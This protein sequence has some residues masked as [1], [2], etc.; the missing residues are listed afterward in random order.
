MS[1]HKCCECPECPQGPQGIQGVEGL[2]GVSGQNGSTGAQGPAGSQGVQGAIGPQGPAGDSGKAEY[3]EVYSNNA[4]SLS[5][6]PGA[7]QAG[8]VTLFENTIVA[9]SG[10]DVSQA[11]TTGDV[12]VNV[13]GWYDIAT[14]SCGSLNPLPSPLPCWTLSLFK[15]GVIVPGSTI[16]QQVVSPEEQANEISADVFVHIVAGDV[17]RLASTSTNVVV[18]SSPTLGTNATVGSCYMKLT[19]MQAV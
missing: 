3:A 8:G 11:A 7:N 2:Q 10:I 16:A 17:L 18:L 6:S 13:T 9:T 5:V 1:H 15:N 12:T 4:Q 14:G 19:L